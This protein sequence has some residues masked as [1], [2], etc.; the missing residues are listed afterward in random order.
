[1]L[2]GVSSETTFATKGIII[3]HD[4]YRSHDPP[5]SVKSEVTQVLI[6]DKAH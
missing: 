2:Y 4:L 5:G 3:L 6:S 1:M